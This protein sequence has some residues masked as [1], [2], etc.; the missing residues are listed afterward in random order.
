MRRS[1]GLVA[2]CV[3][4]LSPGAARARP[5]CI[6]QNAHL[7]IGPG[8]NYPLIGTIPAPTPV[9]LVR[10]GPKWSIVSFDGETGYVATR[11][12]SR[13]SGAPPDP[14]PSRSL[15]TSDPVLV[16]EID[17]L[18]GSARLGGGRFGWRVWSGGDDYFAGFRRRPWMDRTNWRRGDYAAAD[19]RLQCIPNLPKPK[20]RKER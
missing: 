6:Y 7:R 3:L 16:R 9:V 15:T 17:P 13:R 12:L 20:I 8:S 2:I 19:D 10:Q 5:G 4:A 1:V 18:F 14:P 11:H